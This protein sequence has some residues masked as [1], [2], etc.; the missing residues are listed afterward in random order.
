MKIRPFL[1]PLAPDTPGHRIARSLALRGLGAV[2]FAAFASW[3]AQ[4]SLLVGENGLLPAAELLDWLG[5]RL[6]E[7]GKTPFFALPSLFWLTGASD[8]ALLFSC[9]AGCLLALLVV[10]GRLV[11]PA[12]IGLWFLYLSLVSTGS[13]FM[14]YQWDIL[15]LESGLL[16]LFLGPWTSAMRWRRPP[17]LSLANRAALV[18][19]WFLVAKL[20]FLSGWVKLA[21][22]SETRPEWWPEGTAMSYHYMTQPLPTWTAWWMHQL[23]PW[24]HQASL[25]PMYFVEVVLPFALLL[26]RWGRLAAAGGFVGL[27]ALVLL[28]GNYT[29]FNWLTIVLSLTLVHDRVWPRRLLRL[30]RIETDDLEAAA[31]DSAAPCR[32]GALRFAAACPALLALALLNLHIVLRDLHH[33]PAPLLRSDL[34]PRW[35]AR[36]A[37]SLAPFHPVS[38]YGLFRTMTTERPEIV[39]EGSRD[40]LSWFAYDFRWKVD[41]ID[42][43]PRFVAPHQPRLAWQFWFAALEGRYDPASR[44]APWIAALAAKLLE[45]DPGV[46]RFLRR[47]PFPDSPPRYLRARLMRYEFTT[48]PE[49]QARGD[50]WKRVVVGE[51]LPEIARPAQK[52]GS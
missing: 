18:L 43:R 50:W 2:Y 38:G 34:S 26:G 22:A 4:A 41:G 48:L 10:A 25:A 31:E 36:F 28:T 17:A 45:G 19:F 5:P 52:S 35:L 7:Q 32:L 40:G 42:E 23:P 47:D 24:F 33:A 37:E 9:L 16:A 44:N 6:A 30:L 20:M 21:W 12:L 1:A 14:S 46:R 11:G 49:R 27:M 39:V 29:Y 13:V 15:L 3:G 8:A 51:Y